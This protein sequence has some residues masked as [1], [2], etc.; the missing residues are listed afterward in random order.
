MKFIEYGANNLSMAPGDANTFLVLRRLS[1]GVVM[2]RLTIGGARF[3][4]IPGRT[5]LYPS[6]TTVLGVI[7]KKVLAD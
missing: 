3:Y 1:E 7:S 4:E 5:Q 6:V 2:R